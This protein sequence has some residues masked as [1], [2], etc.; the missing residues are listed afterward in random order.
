MRGP[1]TTNRRPQPEPA[2]PWMTIW[3]GTGIQPIL[4]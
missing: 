1:R 3:S 2:D 4:D